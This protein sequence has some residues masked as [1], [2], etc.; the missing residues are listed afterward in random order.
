MT[1][2]L[3]VASSLHGYSSSSKSKWM[4]N[5]QTGTESSNS[6]LKN[7][8]IE[9]PLVSKKKKNNVRTHCE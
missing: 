7:I 4:W 3:Y 2:A 8:P 5:Y 6:L 9:I 1:Q